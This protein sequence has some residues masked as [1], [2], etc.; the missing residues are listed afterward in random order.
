M[1]DEYTLSYNDIFVIIHKIERG[2]SLDD[3]PVEKRKMF[4]DW[5]YIKL[6]D[7][8]A[9][10]ISDEDKKLLRSMR[11]SGQGLQAVK[12]VQQKAIVSLRNAVK[13]IDSL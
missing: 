8:Q 1:D 13:F 5:V 4:A 6:K 3:L 9:R 12:L 2:E 11:A 10:G 7:Q